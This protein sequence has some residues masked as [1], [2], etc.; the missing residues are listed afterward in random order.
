M[1]HDI[2]IL[3]HDRPIPAPQQGL[4][5][6]S[7][8]D[9]GQAPQQQGQPAAASLQRHP[10]HLSGQESLQSYP[11]GQHLGETLQNRNSGQ[12]SEEPAQEGANSLQ[13]RPL[14][15]SLEEALQTRCPSQ[16]VLRRPR[17]LLC[18]W[19]LIGLYCEL[20]SAQR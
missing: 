5:A 20:H 15:E 7:L 19:C 3:P 9:C 11:S 14:G 18:L 1:T 10:S 4:P 8:E 13:Q 2:T 6:V 16:N 12:D 17:C